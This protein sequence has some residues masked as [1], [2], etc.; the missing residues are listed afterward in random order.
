MS[1]GIDLGDPG[2]WDDSALINS[3]DE[4]VEELSGP[5]EAGAEV[6]VDVVVLLLEE[7]GLVDVVP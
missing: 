1:K 7:D 5:V 4:A 2:A 3:W 6:G